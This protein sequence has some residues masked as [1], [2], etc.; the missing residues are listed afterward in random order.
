VARLREVR[1]LA[2]EPE[3]EHLRTAAVARAEVGEAERERIRS[4]AVEAELERAR[5]LVE[6]LDEAVE[7]A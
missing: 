4:G 2:A 5:T 1:A 6:R 7:E 3:Y